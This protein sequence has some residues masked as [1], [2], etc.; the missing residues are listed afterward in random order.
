MACCGP[1]G[2]YTNGTPVVGN[3]NVL[4]ENVPSPS[5]YV[6]Y[7][8]EAWGVAV[9]TYDN[10]LVEGVNKADQGIA[11]GYGTSNNGIVENITVHR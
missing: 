6:A 5:S 2:S 8:I 11:W 3:N 9:R 1:N 7:G 4:I 10:N